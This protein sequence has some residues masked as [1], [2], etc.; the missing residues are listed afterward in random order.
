MPG[1]ESL[2]FMQARA[3][4]LFSKTDRHSQDR[5]MAPVRM[6]HELN[7]ELRI[8]RSETLA[9]LEACPGRQAG[10]VVFSIVDK[11]SFDALQSRIAETRTKLAALEDVIKALDGMG[12]PWHGD[13]VNERSSL[14]LVEPQTSKRISEL[15]ASIMRNRRMPP[16]QAMKEPDYVQTKASL[17]ADISRANQELAEIEPK[18]AEIN[19]LLAS[20]GC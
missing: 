1:I 13:L 14:G 18:L 8:C 11:D 5:T 20:V 3:R 10:T 7:N 12:S 16:D 9:Y 19:R 2:P 17:E 15:L 6:W 4:L